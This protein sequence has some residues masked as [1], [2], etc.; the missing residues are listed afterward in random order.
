MKK[1]IAF[2]T[3]L[4]AIVFAAPN[5]NF[6]KSMRNFEKRMGYSMNG[7]KVT[8]NIASEDDGVSVIQKLTPTFH[9]HCKQSQLSYDTPSQNARGR[10]IFRRR[11]PSFCACPTRNR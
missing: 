10:L 1:V 4:A 6:D 7:A 8:K 5:C 3:V 2:T 9:K 11:M